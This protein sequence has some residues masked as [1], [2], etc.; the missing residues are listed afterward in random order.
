MIKEYKIEPYPRRLWIAKDE[1]FDEIKN[2]FKFWDDINGWN[3]ENIEASYYAVVFRC[4]KDDYA[5]FLIFITDECTD[6]SLVHES[7]HIALHI[8]E[9]CD[10]DLKYGMDQEPF[11]YLL[12]YIYRLIKNGL[13]N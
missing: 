13:D 2:Q 11:C 6:S 4:S 10:M 12:E 5:G 8:Y 9:D 1:N 3:Q 7:G